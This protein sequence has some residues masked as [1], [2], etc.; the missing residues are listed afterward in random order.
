MNR[1]EPGELRKMF[2]DGFEILRYEEAEGIADY[3]QKRMQLVRLIARKTTMQTHPAPNVAADPT[4]PIHR[5]IHP[6]EPAVENCPV[7]NPEGSQPLA[8]G[9][10]QRHPRNSLFINRSSQYYRRRD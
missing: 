10:S 4:S 9:R 6:A 1:Y 8:G 5:K 2:A 7:T 3:G